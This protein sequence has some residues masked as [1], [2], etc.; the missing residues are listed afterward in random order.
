MVDT[1]IVVDTDS[2]AFFSVA[3]AFTFVFAFA[4][5]FACDV[6]LVDGDGS[7]GANDELEETAAD[8]TGA[9]TDDDDDKVMVA[10]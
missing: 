10:A 5:I 6:S 2:A 8:A 9:V 4:F 7:N 1:G 3:L